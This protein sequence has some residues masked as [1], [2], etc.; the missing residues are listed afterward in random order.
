MMTSPV[1][2]VAR[3]SDSAPVNNSTVLVSDTQLLFA[4]GSNSADIIF[5]E[6]FLIVSG[7][8]T[9]SDIKIAWSI[10]AGVTG[11]HGAISGASNVGGWLSVNA[12]TSPAALATALTGTFPYGS[13]AGI[14]GIYHGALFKI[15]GTAGTI[16]LQ[17]AQNT[18]FAGDTKLLS[19]S[20]LRLTKL[21]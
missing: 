11:Y 14:F 7:P 19:G 6:A 18:A 20:F 2:I 8:D 21:A 5:C 13:I 10:P 16:N 12:G 9:T 3:T 15:G 1:Q 4:T 17:W